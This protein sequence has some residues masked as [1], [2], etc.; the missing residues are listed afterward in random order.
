MLLT[1]EILDVA[2]CDRSAL[3]ES[4]ADHLV[5]RFI[6]YA[7]GVRETLD[8]EIEALLQQYITSIQPAVVKLVP[9]G[10][11]LSATLLLP[12]IDDHAAS[13]CTRSC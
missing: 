9:N 2:C 3:I 11:G 13:M 6:T 10:I 8:A 12:L 4:G 1:V 5:L 7:S